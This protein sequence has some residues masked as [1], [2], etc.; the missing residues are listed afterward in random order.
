MDPFAIE[1]LGAFIAFAVVLGALV[2]ASIRT[3]RDVDA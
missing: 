3:S 2:T 1:A